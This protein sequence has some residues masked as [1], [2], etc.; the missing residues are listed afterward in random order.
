MVNV[1][2]WRYE[3]SLIQGQPLFREINFFGELTNNIQ[4]C[5]HRDLRSANILIKGEIAKIADFGLS[6]ILENQQELDG[7]KFPVRY[8]GLII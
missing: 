4:K 5:I 8:T 1:C 2:C 7:G 6:K 3:F